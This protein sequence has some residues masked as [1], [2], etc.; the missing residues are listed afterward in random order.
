MARSDEVRSSLAV[1][2]LMLSLNVLATGALRHALNAAPSDNLALEA[3]AS[4][5]AAATAPAKKEVLPLELVLAFGG[6]Y[7]FLVML[8]SVPVYYRLIEAGTALVRAAVPL[9]VNEKDP[10]VLV[11]RLETREKAEKVIGLDRNWIATVQT[12]FVALSPLL[13]SLLSVLLP[14]K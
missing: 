3:V 10:K 2:G 4:G 13:A 1:L 12:A 5:A 8:L 9:E 7:T 6:A 11:E 14:S